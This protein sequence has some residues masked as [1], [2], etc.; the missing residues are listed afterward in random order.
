VQTTMVYSGNDP[1]LIRRFR[2]AAPDQSC[3]PP[4]SIQDT[5]L[6]IDYNLVLNNKLVVLIQSGNFF[7]LIESGKIPEIVL[8]LD[9]LANQG[10]FREKSLNFF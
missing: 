2:Q 6:I 3:K 9:S 1:D 4:W 7:V 8:S 5:V 10:P